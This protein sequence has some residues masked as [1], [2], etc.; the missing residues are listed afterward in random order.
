M[1]QRVH[2]HLKARQTPTPQG[3]NRL[4]VT[5]SGSMSANAIMRHYPKSQTLFEELQIDRR[6]E[7]YESVDELA[8]RKGMDVSEVINRLR[9]AIGFS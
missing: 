3:T 1:A 9:Q 4:R 5:I 7:G 2:F 6:A 8:W